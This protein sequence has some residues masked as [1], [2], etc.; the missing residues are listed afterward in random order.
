MTTRT[1][2]YS[3]C[4]G[5]HTDALVEPVQATYQ[6]VR[7][8]FDYLTLADDAAAREAWMLENLRQGPLAA[9]FVLHLHRLITRLPHDASNARVLD[10]A[11]KNGIA[12]PTGKPP[13][14]RKALA[15]VFGIL[16]ALVVALVILGLTRT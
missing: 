7:C 12:L 15:I 4:P 5:C 13:S 11:A 3:R 8:G 6:C 2:I 14:A 9:V 1:A 10:F 16:A